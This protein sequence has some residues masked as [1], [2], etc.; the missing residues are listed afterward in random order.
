M[1]DS[2]SGDTQARHVQQVFLLEDDAG[3]G[4][5]LSA[6]S[7]QRLPP[8]PEGV[9]DLLGSVCTALYALPSSQAGDLRVQ[10]EHHMEGVLA[11]AGRQLSTAH[12]TC[13]LKHGSS[14]SPH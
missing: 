4:L 10:A 6:N 14:C 9:S 8:W 12:L 3:G 13:R 5:I 2:S 1:A 7:M 11:E